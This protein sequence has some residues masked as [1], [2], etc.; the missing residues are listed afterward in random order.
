L[1]GLTGKVVEISE[2]PESGSGIRD[3][4]EESGWASGSLWLRGL[5]FH[6]EIGE[7]LCDKNLYL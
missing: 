2:N 7:P 4:E 1:L 6:A 5:I 3:F